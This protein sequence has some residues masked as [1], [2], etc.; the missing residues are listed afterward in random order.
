M[1]T[2]ISAFDRGVLLGLLIGSGS[3]GGDGRNPQIVVKMHTRHEPL[4]RWV[5]SVIPGARV[6]G[7]YAHGGRDYCQLMIRGAAL[8]EILVPLLDESNWSALDPCSYERFA[9]M[10]RRYWRPELHG[11]VSRETIGAEKG[12][13]GPD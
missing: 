12:S 2:A 4:L 8:R 10:K 13:A 1:Q 3:F 9:E 6:F 7:P 5:T 11:A